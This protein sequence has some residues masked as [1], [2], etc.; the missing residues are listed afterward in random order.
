MIEHPGGEPLGTAEIESKR[1]VFGITGQAHLMF[2]DV[3]KDG[4]FFGGE[5]IPGVIAG[6]FEKLPLVVLPHFA[7]R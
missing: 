4:D 6:D 5:V 3:A 7:D 2:S 1:G